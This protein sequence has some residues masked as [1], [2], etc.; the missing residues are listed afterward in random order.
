MSASKFNT[1]ALRVCYSVC[2]VNRVKKMSDMS[3]YRMC[4]FR[5]IYRLRS[6]S[7]ITKEQ[8]QR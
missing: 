8:Q 3:M 6:L 2:D 7:L 5:S 1:H 4:M